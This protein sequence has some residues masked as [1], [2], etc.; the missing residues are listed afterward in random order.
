MK[1]HVVVCAEI[2]AHGKIGRY[3]LDKAFEDKKEAYAYAQMFAKYNKDNIRAWPEEVEL[4]EKEDKE[5]Y[6]QVRFD[7]AYAHLGIAEAELRDVEKQETRSNK[8][9]YTENVADAVRSV[10]NGMALKGL[11][12]EKQIIETTT[13]IMK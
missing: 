13:R 4:I 2:D 10:M 12:S 11:V 1:I 3:Q 5:K 8:T 7:Q 6:I 9:Q